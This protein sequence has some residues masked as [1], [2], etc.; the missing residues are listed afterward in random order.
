MAL[1]DMLPI[2]ERF[3]FRESGCG[4]KGRPYSGHE[5]RSVD[6]F[7][8]KRLC[9]VL[10]SLRKPNCASAD[11]STTFIRSCNSNDDRDV[12]CYSSSAIGEEG[13]ARWRRGPSS[14][15]RH[16]LVPR[17]VDVVERAWKEERKWKGWGGFQIQEP[18]QGLSH[19]C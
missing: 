7:T 2:R 19:Q 12:E 5:W 11:S 8:C 4:Y 1:E 6:G 9:T 17:N 16:Q 15:S 3:T 18:G 13:R 10:P 14:S